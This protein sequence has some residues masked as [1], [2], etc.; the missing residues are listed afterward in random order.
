MGL[1]FIPQVIYE[2][3]EPWW[4]D[5]D[6]GKLFIHPSELYGNPTSSHLVANKEELDKGN[7]EFHL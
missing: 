5:I 3:G 4:N 7:D 1:L 2:H 6:R